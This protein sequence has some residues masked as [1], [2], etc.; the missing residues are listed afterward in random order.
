[1]IAQALTAVVS[2]LAGRVWEGSPAESTTA[3]I[4]GFG[5]KTAAG[6]AVD[7]DRALTHSAVWKAVNLISNTLAKVSMHVLK[8][9]GSN[10]WV[11]DREHFAYR[12]IRRKPNPYMVASQF[13]RTI[14]AHALLWGNGYAAIFRDD[15]TGR[16]LEMYPL[17]PACTRPSSINGRRVY[18][19][20]MGGQPQVLREEDVLHIR[21]LSWDGFAGYNTTEYAKESI[22]AGLAAREFGARFF[23]Q[24]AKSSGIL[25]VP[26]QLDEN[27][28]KRLRKSFN[29]EQS[30]LTDSHRTLIL[31]DGVKYVPL[32]IPPEAA[33]FLETREF[34]LLE[35]A[36]WFGV[37]P[38]KLGHP[39]RTSYNSLEQENQAYLDDSAEPWMGNWEDECNDKLLT[40]EQ[41][42][43]DS[44]RCEFFRDSLKRVDLKTTV[45]VM[46]TELNNGGLTLDQYLQARN[47]P[48]LPGGLGSKHRMPVNLTHLE[49]GPVQGSPPPPVDDAP[50][51]LPPPPAKPTADHVAV[52]E[53]LA[54]DA[55]QR[56]DSRLANQAKQATK[57][58]KTF[59]AWLD[60]AHLGN[61]TVAASMFD[62]TTFTVQK[63][64]SRDMTDEQQRELN[65]RLADAALAASLQVFVRIANTA[66]PEHLKTA[67]Q[68]VWADTV[69]RRADLPLLTSHFPKDPS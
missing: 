56:I 65:Y 46:T 40:E 17:S 10:G 36:N 26:G 13:R 50:P 23:G 61:R 47:R 33:Q 54:L 6:V 3:K 19:T 60:D 9:D 38:H 64:V 63:L 45:E 20:R 14:Q 7:E 58:S 43:N 53:Q 32:T 22:G 41:K 44:H 31:E 51:K 62:T 69:D 48:T 37:P 29:E 52:I 11:R 39:G 12:L 5:G 57:D 67:V 24:G 21:G 42:E 30:K 18:L 35:I 55:W 1:M 4:L 15:A 68:N 27:E 34:D 49:D 59:L 16:P 66:S 2:M 25:H 8:D 28:E